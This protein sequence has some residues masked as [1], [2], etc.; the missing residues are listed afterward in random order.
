[1]IS[2]IFMCTLYFNFCTNYSV[3]ITKSLISTHH[4]T[5]DSLYSICLHSPMVIIIPFSTNKCF[6]LACSFTFFKK[7]STFEWNH[8]VLVFT[9]MIHLAYTL[10]VQLCC[11]KRQ[12]YTFLWLSNIPV[13]IYIPLP[14]SFTHQWTLSISWL[15]QITPQWP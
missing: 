11:H 5:V 4:H 15:L 1:M 3:L 7:Y 13:I 6:C 9:W 8:T 14:Y 10:K 12:D 2:N